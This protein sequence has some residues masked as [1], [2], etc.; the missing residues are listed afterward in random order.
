[1]IPLTTLA[2]GLL[3]LLHN[4]LAQGAGDGFAP[5]SR[6]PD[7]LPIEISEAYL[8]RALDEMLGPGYLN[9]DKS[10]DLITITDKGIKY[11]ERQKIKEADT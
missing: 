7:A 3:A 9:Y 5:I 6:I 10:E 2:H 11:F 1:M 4:H 8:R